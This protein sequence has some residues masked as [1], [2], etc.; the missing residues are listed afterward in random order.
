MADKE[1]FVPSGAV[2]ADIEKGTAP[3]DAIVLHGSDAGEFV[4]PSALT[5][6][7]KALIVKA[8]GPAKA[9]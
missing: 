9:G 8:E 6:S 7:D 3:K 5:K 4:K 1:I 2:I